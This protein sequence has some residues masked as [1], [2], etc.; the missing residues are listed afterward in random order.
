MQQFAA[1]KS[2]SDRDAHHE[3][4]TTEVVVNSSVVFS[5]DSDRFE[6]HIVH[7]IQH[8]RL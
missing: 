2:Q 8:Y 4:D 5:R 6:G 3:I 1:T 7:N